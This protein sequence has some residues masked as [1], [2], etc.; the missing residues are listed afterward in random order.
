MTSRAPGPVC[1]ASSWARSASAGGQL[2]QPSEVKSSTR[3]GPE[4]VEVSGADAAWTARQ[5]WEPATRTAPSTA[6]DA[7]EARTAAR[8]LE[9]KFWL[10]C[11]I[12][13][14]PLP[15]K[16]NARGK[17]YGPAGRNGGREILL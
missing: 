5:A 12:M 10:R 16:T 17:G 6:R 13:L 8:V 2:E 4:P 15:D 3:T 14:L 11:D 7:R 9:W 1:V